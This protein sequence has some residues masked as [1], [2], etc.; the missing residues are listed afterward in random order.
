MDLYVCVQA[1]S[2]VCWIYRSISVLVYPMWQHACGGMHRHADVHVYNCVCR[3]I[4]V[5]T[6]LLVHR[7]MCVCLCGCGCMKVSMGGVCALR[8]TPTKI[9]LLCANVQYSSSLSAKTLHPQQQCTP[10]NLVGNSVLTQRGE[11]LPR[12]C[13]HPSL[14]LI[15]PLK[16]S[17]GISIVS[18]GMVSLLELPG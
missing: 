8:P 12:R 11:H 18:E 13:P 9:L 7:G 14:M 5:Y 4:C 16:E 1:A 2:Y 15:I 3:G 10:H 6:C 17:A